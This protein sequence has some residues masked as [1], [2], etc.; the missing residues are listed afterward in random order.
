M[1]RST[2]YRGCHFPPEI[3][4]YAVWLYA[5]FT[6]SYRDVEELLAQRDIQVSYES[7]R[8][9]CIRFGPLYAQRLRRQAPTQ[10]DVWLLDEVY[11]PIGGQRHYLWRAVDQNGDVI[12]ILLQKRRNGAAAKRF[13]RKLLK[14]QG[15]VPNRL[16]TDKLG[17]YR[18][19][20]RELMP[21]VPHDTTQYSNNRCEASHRATREKERQM[22]RFRRAATAQRFLVLH[23]QV[24]NLMN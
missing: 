20:H 21:T 14:S 13:F 3:I 11:V 15:A 9:W 5:R 8:R 17:S 1:N 12:D 10:G 2:T 16:V 24:R 4:S 19:A 6:L 18:V 22:K 7:I 23:G